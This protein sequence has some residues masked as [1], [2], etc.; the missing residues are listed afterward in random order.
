MNG[1]TALALFHCLFPTLLTLHTS[2]ASIVYPDTRPLP[3]TML[4]S[5]TCN[6]VSV[7]RVSGGGAKQMV[8]IVWEVYAFNWRQQVTTYGS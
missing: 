5:N 3:D 8:Q 4:P 6:P 7:H 2:S 1:S